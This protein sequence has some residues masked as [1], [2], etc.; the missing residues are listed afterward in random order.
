MARGTQ[1]H[2]ERGPSAPLRTA[3]VRKRGTW[4]H[5][6]RVEG[7]WVRRDEAGPP[8]ASAAVQAEA[9]LGFKGDCH[10]EPLSP[11]QVLLVSAEAY[12]RL[13]L[14]PASLRE[15]VTLSADLRGWL[16]GSLVGIGR[17]MLLRLTFPCDPC[18][19][20]NGHRT[21][22]MRAIGT[23]RGML[24]RVVRS[25][26]IRLGD[27]VRVRPKVFGSWSDG[28]QER[29]REVARRVPSGAVVQNAQLAFLAGVPS[30]Y[31]RVF[32]R[33]LA[34]SPGRLGRRVASGQEQ[35]SMP[36]WSGS[37]LFDDERRRP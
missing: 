19:R 24:A 18:S 32:S 2:H 7:L 13:D 4:I 29:V 20:L 23:E 15:N 22:L 8:V 17:R 26:T 25:G 37:D 12:R 36:R 5:S 1:A 9:G 31:C 21:G 34:A 28:W 11:R 30:S 35:P 3:S 14:P 33:V 6:G 16:S 10:A 27:P